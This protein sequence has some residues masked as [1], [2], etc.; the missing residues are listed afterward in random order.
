M[1]WVLTGGRA[2]SRGNVTQGR[3]R[4]S[5][6]SSPRQPLWCGVWGVSTRGHFRLC[7]YIRWLLFS[8]NRMERICWTSRRPPAG[9]GVSMIWFFGVN[10]SCA[11]LATEPSARPPA[12]G[13]G[14]AGD[15]GQEGAGEC[16]AAGQG[17]VAAVDVREIVGDCAMC[18]LGPRHA[19][20]GRR[21]DA[22]RQP[23]GCHPKRQSPAP[24]VTAAQGGRDCGARRLCRG[25]ARRWTSSLSMRRPSRSTTSIRQPARVR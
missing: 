6:A 4:S 13:R 18:V 17:N 5:R 23:M 16:R 2:G 11:A 24:A 10:R 15:A 21:R 20:T 7:R 19:W 3:G 14:V 25:Q 1:G 8:V 22:K 9:P 12:R